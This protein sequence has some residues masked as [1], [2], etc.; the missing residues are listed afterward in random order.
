[1]GT[2]AVVVLD[3]LGEDRLEVAAAE[4]EGVV[5]ALTADRSNESFADGVGSGSADRGLDDPGVFG[6]EDGVERSGELGF[7]I[8]EEKL[9]RRGLVGTGPSRCCGPAG[10]PS[11]R[12]AGR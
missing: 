1:M 11:R 8:M 3:V 10:S 4:D 12:P 7:T 5:E 6:P 9:D 2:V